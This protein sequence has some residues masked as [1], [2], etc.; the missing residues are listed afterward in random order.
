MNILKGLL[1][2]LALLFVTPG[3]MDPPV[4]GPSNDNRKRRIIAECTACGYVTDTEGGVGS[5]QCGAKVRQHCCGLDVWRN[6]WQKPVDEFIFVACK[7]CF[8]KI[9]S[10]SVWQNQHIYYF[11]QRLTN[12]MQINRIFQSSSS[13]CI[14]VLKFIVFRNIRETTS[15]APRYVCLSSVHVYYCVVCIVFSMFVCL[16]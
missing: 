16:V 15:Q 10:K 9:Y 14:V 5:H 7:S 2:P 4:P 11:A 8:T 1:L 6:I 3:S 12:L 13:I